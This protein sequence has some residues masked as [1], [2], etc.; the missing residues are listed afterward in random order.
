MTVSEDVGAT[1]RSIE[2]AINKAIHE[3]K[4]K[5]GIT[6]SDVQVVMTNLTTFGDHVRVY[7]VSEVKLEFKL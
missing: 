4:M 1:K 7:K 6:P 3:L 2:D 5:H